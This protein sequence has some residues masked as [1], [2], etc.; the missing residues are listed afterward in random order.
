[1]DG[2]F[3]MEL[4]GVTISKY[5]LFLLFVHQEASLL[6]KTFQTEWLAN[7]PAIQY[8]SSQ[9]FDSFTQ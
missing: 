6:A 4:K 2:R 1:M 5:Q 3:E 7:D 9:S 8:N